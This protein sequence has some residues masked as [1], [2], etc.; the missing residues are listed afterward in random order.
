MRVYF[1]RHAE[2]VSNADLGVVALPP[3]RGD[4]LTERGWEQARAAGRYLAGTDLGIERLLTSPMRRARET[5]DGV[6]EALGLEPAT[7]DDSQELRESEGYGELTPEEQRLHRWS[8]W[9]AEHGDD[10]E[11]SYQGGE[12]FNDLLA[13]V[14]SVKGALEGLAG[15]ASTV[16][17][18]VTHG[19]W[20]RF[21]L[22]ECLLGHGFEAT[23]VGRLWQVRTV[24]CGL[25]L[26]EYVPGE[27][28]EKD[29]SEDPW[30]CMTWMA[31]PWDPP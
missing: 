3:E 2:S 31:R 9:M 15:E 19:I 16:L 22:M 21:F 12:S 6:A 25:S 11:Y 29:P 17:L 7:L 5:A 26:F 24:N 23:E 10:P 14:R 30:R 1:L 28:D 8:V 18:V 27:L 13:R 20:L 4:Q